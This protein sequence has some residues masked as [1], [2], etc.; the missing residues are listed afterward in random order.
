MSALFIRRTSLHTIAQSQRSWTEMIGLWIDIFGCCSC[1]LTVARRILLIEQELRTHPEYITSV[2]TGVRVTQ[3]LIFYALFCKSVFV[4]LS[5][6]SFCHC[7]I[8]S[9]LFS[10]SDYPLVS[11]N[12]SFEGPMDRYCWE[13]SVWRWCF[14]LYLCD[15]GQIVLA[16]NNINLLMINTVIIHHFP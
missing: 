7:I 2:F 13:R 11:S 12:F 9:S 6:F 16:F 5:F 1:G 3:S 8:Y 15:I 4:L 14:D 10:A